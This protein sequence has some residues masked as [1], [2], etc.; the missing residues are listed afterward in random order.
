MLRFV[1]K[2]LLYVL[3]IALGVSIIC[4]TLVYLAIIAVPL[5]AFVLYRTPW[6]LTVRMVGENPR[7]ADSASSASWIDRRARS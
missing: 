5:A 1:L 7:A 6:G 3:P 4:F 2:R